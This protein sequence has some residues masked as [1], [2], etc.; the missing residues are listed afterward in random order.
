MLKIPTGRRQTSWLF[1]SV[2]E[3]GLE[4]GTSG[5]QV[6]RPYHWATPPPRKTLVCLFSVGL[7]CEVCVTLSHDCNYCATFI[8]FLAHCCKTSVALAS[9]EF[10]FGAAITA[11][12]FEC[13]LVTV[14]LRVGNE[15]EKSASGVLGYCRNKN[16]LKMRVHSK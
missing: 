4:P 5:F 1:T 11:S 8:R 15:I 12:N 9:S 10:I 6:R 16:I 3:A 14:L 7:I 13:C 2:A